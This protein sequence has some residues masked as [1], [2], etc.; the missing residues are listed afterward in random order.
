MPVVSMPAG[1]TGTGCQ[2]PVG[3]ADNTVRRHTPRLALDE[4]EVYLHSLETCMLGEY[5]HN[6]LYHFR[7]RLV[8]RSRA[9][10]ASGRGARCTASSKEDG[11]LMERPPSSPRS[12]GG[13][14]DT[15]IAV[16]CHVFAAVWGE[17]ATWDKRDWDGGV[18]AMQKDGHSHC[19]VITR[20]GR[21]AGDIGWSPR[22][23]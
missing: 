11:R 9:V 14:P 17:T 10:R 16:L 4:Y 18:P 12:G 6:P 5:F 3:A 8:S 2:S 22:R 7:G 13:K 20:T 19:S 23:R 21:N 15:S 1:I